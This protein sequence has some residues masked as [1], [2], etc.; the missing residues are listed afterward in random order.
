[1]LDELPERRSMSPK[2]TTPRKYESYLAQR[3]AE[4]FRTA[5][6]LLAEIQK[7]GYTGSLTH[8]ERLLSEWHRV[9]RGPS[10]QALAPMR[11]AAGHPW[12]HSKFPRYRLPIC[13]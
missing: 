3:W 11:E 4:G 13:V 7:L 8:M 1:M 2:S 9:R 12:L 5:R 10:V 6:H